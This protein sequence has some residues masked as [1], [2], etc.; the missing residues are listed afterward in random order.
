MLYTKKESDEVKI[1]V[2]VEMGFGTQKSMRQNLGRED[3]L[4]GQKTRAILL[5][6]GDTWNLKKNN[7][8]KATEEKSIASEMELNDNLSKY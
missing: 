3:L 6:Y 4:P 7:L 1:A 5:R 2:I 8:E